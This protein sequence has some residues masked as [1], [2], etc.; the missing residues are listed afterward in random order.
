MGD[1]E[2]LTPFEIFRVC[3]F[4]FVVVVVVA[5]VVAVVV[6]YFFHFSRRDRNL[7][8]SLKLIGP[9]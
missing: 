9:V 2:I 6:V 5:V 4:F 1:D 8:M 7:H 3:V